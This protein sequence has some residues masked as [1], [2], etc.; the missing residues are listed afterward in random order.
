MRVVLDASVALTFV[1]SDERDGDA[2]FLLASMRRMQPLV[3]RTW[4]AE[5]VN[6]LLT[7]RLRRRIDDRGVREGINLLDQLDVNVDDEPPSMRGIYDLAR[8]FSLTAY[9][10]LYLE[11]A[12]RSGVRLITNDAALRAAARRAKTPLLERP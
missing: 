5:V 6:A 12:D 8:E 11:L 4:H 1:I 10:A 9:D 7:A 2:E 3:P